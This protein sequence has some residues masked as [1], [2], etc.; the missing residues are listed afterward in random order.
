MSS[1]FTSVA[2][3][4][5]ATPVPLA[6]STKWVTNVYIKARKPARGGAN[7][8]SLYLGNSL[9]PGT[10]DYELQPGEVIG[11]GA[12][13]VALVDLSTLT[14]EG[15]NVGDGVEIAYLTVNDG[16]SY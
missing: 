4:A 1:G 10:N 8:G 2:I 9:T 12:Y 16:V 3:A 14:I 6:S 15:A 5:P 11:L 13:E 7:V